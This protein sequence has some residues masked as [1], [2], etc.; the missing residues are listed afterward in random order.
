MK[1]TLTIDPRLCETD[2]LGRINNTS[3]M[4]WLEE[5]RVSLHHKSAGI[6]Q[7][8]VLAQLDVSYLHEINYPEPVEVSTA[9]ESLGNSS[10]RYVQTSSQSAKLCLQA[11]A[12]SVAFNTETRQA[13]KLSEETKLR[14]APWMLEEHQA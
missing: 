13:E 5:G 6:E 10:I 1:Q 7:S 4:P 9:I 3:V 12:V 11:R 2:R 14:L 8:V